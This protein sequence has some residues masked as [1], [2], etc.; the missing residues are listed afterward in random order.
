[1]KPELKISEV[2]SKLILNTKLSEESKRSASTLLKR[3]QENSIP[4]G[5]VFDFARS[6]HPL[7]THDHVNGTAMEIARRLEGAADTS[8]ALT[9]VPSPVL[10]M[11]TGETL[12]AT[13]LTVSSS[14]SLSSPSNSLEEAWQLL[15]DQT[16]VTDVESLSCLLNEIGLSNASELLD[17]E[18]EMIQKIA[19]FLKVV[20]KKKFIRLVLASA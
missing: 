8:V 19:S 16:K 17:C 4:V 18:E 13:A 15:S 9:S 5:S 20:P 12:K 11:Q 7:W 14:S 3:L 10:M 6:L 2:L 1:M